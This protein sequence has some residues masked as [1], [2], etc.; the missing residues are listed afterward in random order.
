MKLAATFATERV[1]PNSTDYKGW[2][3]YLSDVELDA[4]RM[5]LFL[6]TKGFLPT[7]FIGKQYTYKNVLSYLE[8]VA[9]KAMTGD[10]VV[11]YI[12]GHGTQRYDFSGD[13]TD[14]LDEGLCC[15]D[16]ILYDDDIFKKIAKIKEGVNVLF[17][18]DTC[19]SG[20]ML[21]V[22]GDKKNKYS[23]L[24]D[25]SSFFKGMFKAK[26]E[27][28]INANVVL[29]ASSRESQYSQ[30][31]GNGGLF[32]N[33]F[34]SVVDKAIN[35]EQALMKANNLCKNSSGLESNMQEP[36]IFK[37]GKNPD[38]VLKMKL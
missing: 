3:G 29:L 26:K 37:L 9:T 14:R 16:N 32:T 33:A 5:N 8:S 18:I 30:S 11:I 1:N 27:P 36:Q 2:D 35:L 20:T 21:K 34:L 6:G 17:I 10:T 15:Y 28:V 4:R 22:F 12:S 23:I 24:S 13:E 31:T 25:I 7:R 38:N 19:H